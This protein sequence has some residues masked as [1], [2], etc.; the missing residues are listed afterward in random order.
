MR[1]GL[2]SYTYTWA[3]GVPGSPPPRPLGYRELVDRAVA[4]GV[5]V[6]QFADNLPLDALGAAQLE[7]L[8]AH[9]RRH[10][11]ALEVGTRGIDTL[12]R[13]LEVAIVV[14]SP[15]VRLVVDADGDEPTPEQAVAR[16]APHEAAFR[17]AGRRLAIENHD[18]FTTTQLLTIL[19]GLGDWVGICLDTVN[20]FG[21]LEGPEVVLRALG[22]RAI[23]LHLKDFRIRRHRHQMGFEIEGTPVGSGRLDV[24]WLLDR[25]AAGRIDSAI[26]ELWTPPESDIEATVA[27]EE[28]W[29][30]QSL[31]YLRRLPQLEFPL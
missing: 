8:A 27:K 23:N 2:S 16:I 31:S 21:S 24:P 13:N 11:I 4:A 15:F 20:S 18:R 3:V 30:Q 14:G 26:I 1:V 28:R 25:L 5:G 19:D 6:V 9:A 22:P 7:D 12:A 10:R 17:A 29:A